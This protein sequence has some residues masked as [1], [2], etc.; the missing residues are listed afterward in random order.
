MT[1]AHSRNGAFSG[2]HITPDG[3]V[4]FRVYYRD[5]HIVKAMRAR[6]KRPLPP[7]HHQSIR[8]GWLWIR[9]PHFLK[10]QFEKSQ[11]LFT[12]SRGAYK[13]ACEALSK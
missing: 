6:Q 4:G 2:Y 11:G 3:R 10:L 1:S 5:R 8:T 13:A 12:S 7:A 9:E